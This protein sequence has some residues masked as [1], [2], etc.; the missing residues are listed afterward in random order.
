[1]SGGPRSAYHAHFGSNPTGILVPI[2]QDRRIPYQAVFDE[3]IY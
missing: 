2:C 1:M 3:V